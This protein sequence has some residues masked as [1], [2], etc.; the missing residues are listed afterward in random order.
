MRVDCQHCAHLVVSTVT[1]LQASIIS[2]FAE[3]HVWPL[4]VL[5]ESLSLEPAVLRTRINYW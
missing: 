5:A 4:A 2:Q 1:P 3:R